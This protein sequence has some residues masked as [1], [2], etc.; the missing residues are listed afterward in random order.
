MY[1][2][3]FGQGLSPGLLGCGAEAE[4]IGA[5]VERRHWF[6][7]GADPTPVCEQ[8]I[9]GVGLK[10]GEVVEGDGFASLSRVVGIGIGRPNG[11]AGV[12]NPV[13]F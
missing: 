2:R 8:V 4:P 11:R 1:D 3:F 6:A 9:G 12:L 10:G 13:E 7:S 5:I